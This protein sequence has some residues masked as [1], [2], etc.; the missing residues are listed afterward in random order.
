MIQQDKPIERED[1]RKCDN[2]SFGLLALETLL[3]GRLYTEKMPVAVH[4]GGGD[5]KGVRHE[6]ILAFALS[7][8]RGYTNDI[9]GGFIRSL[10]RS[11]LQIDPQR[12]LSDLT[13][14][15]IMRKWQ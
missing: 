11:L 7:S 8:V 3:D 4:A 14:L 1:L 13:E 9:Q 12:R 15:G 5:G 10:F 2:W 6:G